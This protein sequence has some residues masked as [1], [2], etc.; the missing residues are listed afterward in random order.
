[1]RSAFRVPAT[2]RESADYYRPTSYSC[3]VGSK[4]IQCRSS[5]DQLAPVRGRRSQRAPRA[6]EE[7]GAHAAPVDQC[8]VDFARVAQ[9]LVEA[10][11]AVRHA[12]QVLRS[13]HLLQR[14][15]AGRKIA[16]T[17]SQRRSA[18]HRRLHHARD[19]AV[20]DHVGCVRCGQSVVRHPRPQRVRL[21]SEAVAPAAALLDVGHPVGAFRLIA[22]PDRPPG[23]SG[24]APDVDHDLLERIVRHAPG[25]GGLD[26]GHE[27]LACVDHGLDRVSQIFHVH[28]VQAVAECGWPEELQVRPRSWR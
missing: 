8:A 22:V 12:G 1:M 4:S 14:D 6:H 18:F 21:S 3:S 19:H 7:Q 24:V 20:D 28:R 2:R 11:R 10:R 25:V 27:V 15:S 16:A 5:N 26:L 23:L 9:R 13:N 17:S